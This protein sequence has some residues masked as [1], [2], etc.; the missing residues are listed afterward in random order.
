MPDCTHRH[1]DDLPAPALLHV[2]VGGPRTVVGAL[3]GGRA[4]VS[5]Q[6]T[7]QVKMG[8]PSCRGAT[9]GLGQLERCGMYAWPPQPEPQSPPACPLPKPSECSSLV[10]WAENQHQLAWGRHS[11]EVHLP[12]GS[13][14]AHRASSAWTPGRRGSAC[15]GCLRPKSGS[16]AE[17]NTITPSAYRSRRHCKRQ[18]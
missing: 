7:A 3:W 15:P 11:M 1:E 18:V 2:G 4:G 8:Q 16:R 5:R 10:S 17:A 9:V 14:P 6:T 12:P 13:Q